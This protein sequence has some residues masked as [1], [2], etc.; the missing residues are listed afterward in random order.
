MNEVN[1]AI[2]SMKLNKASG[3]TGVVIDMIRALDEAGTEWLW[4]L[5]E[6][7]WKEEGMPFDWE[8]S[9]MVYIYKQKGDAME[10][11][12]YR[13]IKLME[14][15]L[16]VFE[17]VIV[18]KLRKIV[19]IHEMQFGFMPGKST[20][21]AIFITRQVQE[22][23][24]EGNRKL[25]WC[26]VDLEKAFDR[27][28]RE[29]MYWCLRKRG[30]PERLVNMIK[31]IY[32]G[33]RTVVR[34]RS[35]KTEPFEVKVGLHQGSALSPFLFAV[36]MDVLSENVRRDMLWDLLFADYL[37]ITAETEE[38]LQERYRAWQEN[39]ERGGLRVNVGKTE[40]MIS[41]RGGR[42]DL[43]IRTT[44]GEELK[45]TT[46]FK[47]LGSVISEEGGCELEVRQRIKAGW[48]K[49]RQVSGV[50]LDKKVPMK[51]R[52]KVYKTVIRPVL[53]YGSET[54]A[55]RRKEEGALERTEMR[56]LRWI[57]GISLLERIESEDIRKRA[58][59]CKITDKACESRMRWY[60]HVV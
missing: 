59:V 54:W 31:M 35:G 46:S 57:L 22:K 56:M 52:I 36:V 13:G 23:F 44:A 21:D 49:W 48:A 27:V 6:T 33:A 26:F 2:Q 1:A 24:L 8:E 55:M 9:E 4:E 40:V 43:H 14:H 11:G 39:L 45:Q 5:I 20:V 15:A 42:E 19:S 7:I 38:Q 37:V 47:Y 28:P 51:L 34:T 30:V 3:P 60:G 50:I 10:C 29:V 18:G 16:K 32:K 53:L 58:G 41:S 17:R 25:Y 12:N